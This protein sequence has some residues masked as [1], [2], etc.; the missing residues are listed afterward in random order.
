M[1]ILNLKNSGI[2]SGRLVANVV[3]LFLEI[4]EFKH[5][6]RGSTHMYIV[7]SERNRLY[8]FLSESV[9]VCSAAKC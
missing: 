1:G 4:M 3:D 7:Q 5:R 2:Q 9:H 8:I 6:K